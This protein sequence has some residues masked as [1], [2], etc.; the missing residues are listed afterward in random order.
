MHSERLAALPNHG[1]AAGL[2][3]AGTD[4]QALLPELGVA[5]P[6][7][8]R[9]E[10]PDAEPG[11]F[12]RGL[13]RP[14]NRQ[15]VVERPLLQIIAPGMRSLLGGLARAI[16][17]MADFPEFFFGMPQIHDMDRSGTL[18]GSKLPDP[19]RAV[20]QNDAPLGFRKAVAGRHP[21]HAQVERGHLGIRVAGRGALDR[22]RV[23]HR[24]RVTL[25]TALGRAG[26]G[27]PAGH[28]FALARLGAAI[29]W[30]A[31]APDGLG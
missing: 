4:A 24:T 2:D 5:Y 14:Q 25:G 21:P 28:H 19:R 9:L 8:V 22:R 12:A 31:R 20:P 23:A 18:V 17:R 13:V 29:R 7:P 15:Q 11:G 6:G 1:L 27:G 10:I 3:H 26:L 16:E 30:L